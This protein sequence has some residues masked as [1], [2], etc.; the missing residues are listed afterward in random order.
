MSVAVVTATMAFLQHQKAY[1]SYLL[2]AL[3]VLPRCSAASEQKGHSGP[4]EV[5][6][7]P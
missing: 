6:A 2:V 3:K 1:P 5:I 4:S 7:S